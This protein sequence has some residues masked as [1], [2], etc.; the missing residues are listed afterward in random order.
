MKPRTKAQQALVKLSESLPPLTEFQLKQAEAKVPLRLAKRSASG[1]YVCLECAHRWSGEKADEVICPH[2]GAKLST[3]TSRKINFGT[4]GYFATISRHGGYQVVRQYLMS[5]DLRKGRKARITVHEVFQWWITPD[6]AMQVISRKRHTLGFYIDTW[7]LN[8]PLE[9][10]AAHDA[11][12]IAPSFVV[13]RMSV[14]P[15]IA[16]AG[17]SGDLHHISPAFLFHH[18][19]RD[20]RMETLW[21]AGQHEI[22]YELIYGNR[23]LDS[24]WPS[25]KVVNRHGYVP[26]DA[27]MWFDLLE[28]LRRL[29]KD[30]LNP[31]LICPANLKEAHDICVRRVRAK[32]ERENRERERINRERHEARLAAEAE[33]RQAEYVAAKAKFF[34]LQ[35]SD[36]KIII[37]PLTSVQEFMDEGR[38]MQHCVFTNEYYRRPNCLIFHAL[39]DGASVATIEFNLEYMKIMQC[40]GPHNCKPEQYDRICEIINNNKDKIAQKLTA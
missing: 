23:T 39:I 25:I 30:V 15:E 40:R 3:D 5:K 16:R 26:E 29:G 35:F 10:R 31:A 37:R 33:I 20:S 18:L 36:D 8:S 1:E 21:K 12:R 6:G 19:L 4:K 34:D 27:S 9:L 22:V 14:V 24:W 17:F 32:W 11:H 38:V 13:G 7:D 28:S 2:C